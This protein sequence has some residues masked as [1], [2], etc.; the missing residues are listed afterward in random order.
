MLAGAGASNTASEADVEVAEAAM[1]GALPLGCRGAWE[2]AR[3][4][5]GSSMQVQHSSR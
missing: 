3:H 5:A 2:A 4:A 1:W